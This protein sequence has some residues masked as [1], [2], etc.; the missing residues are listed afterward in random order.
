MKRLSEKELP[1]GLPLPWPLFDRNGLL[2]IT[3]GNVLRPEQA[4]DLL[5]SGVYRSLEIEKEITEFYINITKK[6]VSKKPE[7]PKLL[8]NVEVSVQPPPGSAGVSPS[9]WPGWPR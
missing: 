1:I 9:R 4:Q 3:A 2:L 7:I 6:P 8:G 5:S